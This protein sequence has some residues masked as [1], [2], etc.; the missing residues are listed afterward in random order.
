MGNQLI[1]AAP[2]KVI[3]L[4]VK[5]EALLSSNVPVGTA[6]GIFFVLDIT[7]TL[8]LEQGKTST[9]DADTIW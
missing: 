9:G 8:K 2:L 4:S 5:Q 3:S 1:L 7:T 6:V